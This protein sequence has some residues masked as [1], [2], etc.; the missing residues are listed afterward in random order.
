MKYTKK[1]RNKCKK[2]FRK[3][4]KRGG[5][6]LGYGATGWVLGNPDHQT[7]RIIIVQI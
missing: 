4:Y 2:K 6:V 1:Y 7:P 3:T 5:E